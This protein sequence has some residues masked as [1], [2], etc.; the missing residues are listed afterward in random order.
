MMEKIVGQ[1]QWYYDMLKTTILYRLEHI[2][3]NDLNAMMRDIVS[4]KFMTDVSA[5]REVLVWV[6][7][8]WVKKFDAMLVLK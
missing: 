5:M 3:Y 6:F 1:T 2:Y 4:G 8:E 7:P